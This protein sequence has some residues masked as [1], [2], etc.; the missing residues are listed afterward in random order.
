MTGSN[1]VALG[2]DAADNTFSGASD[3]VIGEAAATGVVSGSSDVIIG[4][5]A[6]TT[7]TS[8]SDN[9]A[10]GATSQIGAALSN[11][12]AIGYGASAT[13]SA[14]IQEGNTSVTRWN[15]SSNNG[16]IDLTNDNYYFGAT[17]SGNGYGP[18]GNNDAG[19]NNIAMGLGA[20]GSATASATNNIALGDFA[21]SPVTGGEFNTVVGFYAGR[22]IGTGGSSSGVSGATNLYTTQ[23]FGNTT[24]GRGTGYS[25][26]DGSLNTAVGLFAM[27]GNFT[28][29]GTVSGNANTAVGFEALDVASGSGIVSNTA[30]GATALLNNTGNQ[31]VAVGDSALSANTTGEGNTALGYQANV[32][33]GALN[34]A[35]AIGYGASAPVSNSVT[36]GNT[37]VTG[38]YIP[39]SGYNTPGQM[40]YTSAAS[41]LLT[42]I[43][44]GSASQVLTW[45]GGVPTWSTLASATAVAWALTGNSGTTP[46]INFIGTTD[47]KALVF[48]TDGVFSGT[49]DPINFNAYFG[50]NAGNNSGEGNVAIGQ[51]A[52]NVNNGNDNVAVGDSAALLSKAGFNTALGANALTNNVTGSQNT[53]VGEGALFGFQQPDEGNN[54]TAI[55]S[56]AMYFLTPGTNS[57]TAV[58]WFA[59][60]SLQGG[61][62]NVAIGDST[63]SGYWL[64]GNS[65][66]SYNVAI[67][68]SAMMLDVNGSSNV[69]IG[70][71]A[72]YNGNVSQAVAVGDS[73]MANN[74]TGQYNTALGYQSLSV[75]TTGSENTALGYQA[76]VA[77]AALTNA[78]AIGYQAT[79]PV[80][81]SV[82]LGNTAATALY[83]PG[84]N[85]PNTL[86]YTT[87]GTGLVGSVAAG[88]TGQILVVNATGVPTWTNASAATNAWNVTGGNATAAYAFSA[89]PTTYLGTNASGGTGLQFAVSGNNAGRIETSASNYNTA[90]GYQALNAAT[91]GTG[92]AQNT[93]I[94]YNALAAY[95]A[96][97]GSNVAIGM[98]SMG[99]AT[100]GTGNVGVGEN[101]FG[102]EASPGSNNTAVGFAAANFVTGSDNV[103]LGYFAFRD[104]TGTGGNY[105][106]AIGWEA[107]SSGYTGNYDNFIGYESGATAGGT[108]SGSNNDA[109]GALSENK[110]TS[111][112]NNDAVG[113]S[114]LLNTT[115]GSNNVA[116][117]YEA[118]LTNV[119]SSYNTAVGGL[120]LNKNTGA[121][122]TAV[123]YVADYSNTSGTDNVAI[124]DSS[125]YSNTTNS[126]SVAVGAS[127]LKANTGAG[128]VAVGNWAFQSNTTVVGNTGVGYEAAEFNTTGAANTVMGYQALHTNTNTGENIAIGYQALLAFPGTAN[129]SLLTYNTAIGYQ[130]EAAL[131]GYSVNNY[132]SGNV[133]L[134]DFALDAAQAVSDNVAIGLNAGTGITGNATGTASGFN[135]VIIGWNALKVG[136]GNSNTA[137]GTY[138]LETATSA[139]GM[140]TAMGDSSLRDVGAGYGNTALGYFADVTSGITN[141]TAI[142]SFSVA[143]ASNQIVL[144]STGASRGITYHGAAT[145][146]IGINGAI[147]PWNGAAYAPGIAGNILLSAGAGAND[148]W[149]ANGSV[150]QVLTISGGVPTWASPITSATAWQLTGNSGTTP[151]TNFI[152]TTDANALEFKTNNAISG[153]LDPN[154]SNVYFGT[155]AGDFGGGATQTVAIGYQ[156]GNVNT[157]SGGNA[158]N[159]FIGYQAGEFNGSAGYNQFEGYQAGQDNT[160]G[161]GNLYV[162]YQ[163]GEYNVSGSGNTGIGLY[164]ASGSTASSNNTVVGYASLWSIGTTDGNNTVLGADVAAALGSGNNNT[165][166]GYNAMQ[167]GL[168]GANYNVAVGSNSMNT[169][170]SGSYNTVVGGNANVTGNVSY[171]TGLGYGSVAGSS[172]TAIGYEA[173]ATQANS[174]VLG[175]I[176]GVNSAT[177]NT[178]VAI[179]TQTPKSLLDVKGGVGIGTYA[180]VNAAPANG[181]IVSGNVGIGTNAPTQALQVTGNVQFSQALMPNA[182]PG[183]LGNILLSAGAA[184]APTWLANGTAGQVL[185]VSGG[186]PTW[187]TPSS[188]SPGDWQLTGNAVGYTFNAV[189]TTYLGTTAGNGAGFQFGIGGTNAGRVES[190]NANT[191]I[192]YQALNANTAVG[193]TAFG[194]TALK[195]NTTAINNTVVGYQ[196]LAVSTGAGNTALGNDAGLDITTGI[197]NIALG[198]S[199]MYVYPGTTGAPI[200]GIHNIGIGNYAF[201]ASYFTVTG[202]NNIGMGY[203]SLGGV[204]GAASN[205]IGMGYETFSGAVNAMTGS[206]NIGMGF[207]S[208]YNTTTGSN[209][210]ALGYESLLSNQSG[211]NNVAIGSNAL[212]VASTAT[213][214]SNTAVGDSAMYTYANPPFGPGQYNVALGASALTNAAGIVTAAAQENVAIGYQSLYHAQS[215][216]YNVA[217]GYQSM[218][219]F[220]NAS[221]NVAVGL[222]ALE[223]ATGGSSTGNNNTAIGE[224]AIQSTTSGNGNTALGNGALYDNTTGSYNTALGYFANFNLVAQSY[225]TAIGAYSQPTTSN[226]IVLGS[227]GAAP[228]NGSTVT[229][230]VAVN[231]AL[232]PWNGAI[233]NPGS[234]GNILL[235]A[236]AGLNDTWLGNGTT[237]QV[238]TIAGGVPT[239]STP[240]TS[241]TAWQL[242][243]NAGTTAGTN[244]IGTTDA[245][246]LVFKTAGNE[247]M[248]IANAT[249]YVGIGT[250]A[251][252]QPLFVNHT[253][254]ANTYAI[255]SNA[256]QTNLTG[257]YQNVAMYG[258]A[259]AGDNAHGYE[260]GVMGVIHPVAHGGAALYG[261]INASGAP[262][263]SQT[264][265]FYGIY[266]DAN[267]VVSGGQTAYAAAFMNGNVGV[268][269]ATPAQSLEVGTTTGTVRIDGMKTGNTFNVAAATSNSNLVFANNSTGDLSALQSGA[270][271]QVLSLNGS[272]V[273]TWTTLTTSSTAWQLT[274]NAGTTPGTNFIGTTD[275]QPLIFKTNDSISGVINPND[276]NGS[277]FLGENAGNYGANGFQTIAIGYHAGAVNTVSENQFIGYE[278]GMNYIG[279]TGNDDWNLYEGYQAGYN[280]KQGIRNMFVGYQSGYNNTGDAAETQGYVNEFVG[281]KAGLGNTTGWENMMIGYKTGAAGTTTGAY[282]T[283]VGLE[284]QYALNGGFD[285]TTVGLQ[286][287]Y[288]NNNG[289]DNT[290]VGCVAMFQNVGTQNTAIGSGALFGPLPAYASQGGGGNPG[291][292]N[293]LTGNNNVAVGFST[294]ENDSTGNN[295]T[296]VGTFALANI[297][298]GT[299]N[300]A[301]GYYAMIGN[302]NTSTGYAASQN[303]ITGSN[304]TALGYYALPLISTS[305]LVGAASN[306]GIGSY[307]LYNN[308]AS[309]ETAV[310]D[311]AMAG[312]TTGKF[313]TAV[314]YQSL[315]A[316]ITGSSNTAIGYK[317]N[318]A[319]SALTNA[320]AVGANATVS[321]SNT[322]QL[323]SGANVQFDL[324]LMPAGNAGTSGY[325][326]ESQG[327]GVAPTWASAASLANAWSLTGNSGT[328]AGTNFIGTTDGHDLVF[329]TNSTE[330]MRIANV[331]GNV[332]INNPTPNSTLSV[333]GSMS[334]NVTN[335]SATYPIASTDYIVEGD[336]STSSFNVTLP[337]A[338]G[339]KGRVYLIV[340]YDATFNGSNILTVGTTSSQNI[341]NYGTSVSLSN[342]YEQEYVASDGHNW[343]VIGSSK[344]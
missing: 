228:G 150:G 43:T 257:D 288:Y 106:V 281:Y 124:G 338:T 189:P 74:T 147:S 246:D 120:A 279:T 231:G 244:F 101:T 128:N 38:L 84:Y 37:S 143:T 80:S 25:I 236:G 256:I 170:N 7:L 137:V 56:Q 327:A 153:V 317:A 151:G 240:S 192:G 176:S 204:S 193:N 149:L 199:A 318:A 274:G 39:G 210:I 255:T 229:S 81:N 16:V 302:Y 173:D 298:V 140:N 95:S 262:T 295:N 17:A 275:D 181:L 70:R 330:N 166:L 219:N 53:A 64:P 336:C 57:N 314:G 269:T 195:A 68:A 125:L 108:V 319:T 260:V 23:S 239:W 160:T 162:G 202:S 342:Q 326:L 67:G 102:S 216:S 196:S 283:S 209:N 15:F 337:D 227:N 146:Q 320:T 268:G 213:G 174:L 29:N 316:N 172:A 278:A 300:T 36:L 127:A 63:F 177:S 221:G 285:N 134:G 116:I 197:D 198:D 132:G 292:Y 309:L 329:K 163:A 332:G 212:Q 296:A 248:R 258:F 339:C 46:G 136:S 98:G 294:L 291:S 190:T 315:A 55:G 112:A 334:V 323:G 311:S 1:N 247:D 8:G 131:V 270:N 263:Y 49:L 75:N 135:N 266:T 305:N 223:G 308:L 187:S 115:T 5:G 73:A 218:R 18:A 66:S 261:A 155:S 86:L 286:A 241:A 89:T 306:T 184:T 4:Q 245:Q 165:L 26:T 123:G 85:T 50:T 277:V 324:A 194:Y 203:Y 31:N 168:S 32:S 211:N 185:T 90:L 40:Y 47:A 129:T 215:S 126:S 42:A 28:G 328:T 110:V 148:T 2:Y 61:H 322:V 83:I 60:G 178:N 121:Q 12:T 99:I 325:V 335:V 19:T 265:N 77:S 242:L 11:A 200:T 312:N 117:G 214:S 9:T 343:I 104:Q 105:G 100:S 183:T 161:T 51:L 217:L 97:G 250:N 182:L 78:T 65:Y 142:G 6:G 3:V 208:S 251:P 235:S 186:V 299:N 191:A 133:A 264:N 249:G 344:M 45:T 94:G 111:G 27:G 180:G 207:E 234:N 159:I 232:S 72:L 233:Y 114:A 175:A 138:A 93:A 280:D 276:G 341:G 290:A 79:A 52:L 206:N 62:D 130:A 220:E 87:A 145:T 254:V 13:A 297:T 201:T 71:N 307:S 109:L 33:S 24:I 205:N 284:S 10:I 164:A 289:N 88:T 152:G 41:G 20:L 225:S 22:Y 253:D 21:L 179:G 169:F 54:N 156:A 272:G 287:D 188:T 69:A 310:G 252:T 44:P 321:A 158:G 154:G 157:A 271:G 91:A 76:N 14:E 313:N 92:G 230:Q 267:A 107:G 119:S 243:G 103:A 48:K 237:G 59:L 304:N 226:Q 301:L 144:G 333:L 224:N 238:L 141:A 122:N 113:Y 82:T 273:P 139:T 58:G 96:S 34:N 30:I 259:Q 167:S 35:T 222:Q 340:R 293:D 303:G 118:S 331:S 171:A 282:N